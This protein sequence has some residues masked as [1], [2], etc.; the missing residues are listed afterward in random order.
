[1]RRLVSVAVTAIA[2]C[3]VGSARTSMSP[4]MQNASARKSS[5][6]GVRRRVDRDFSGAHLVDHQVDAEG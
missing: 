3:V 6:A 4:A 2:L 1:M 5:L